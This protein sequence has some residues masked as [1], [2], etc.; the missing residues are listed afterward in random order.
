MK[1]TRRE[2]LKLTGLAASASLLL[3][4]DKAFA[5][6]V[7]RD[8]STQVGM[9]VDTTRCIGCQ[10]CEIAC[11]EANGLPPPTDKPN[12]GQRR[13]TGIDAYTVVNE[14]ESEKS[15]IFCKTQCM[16]CDQP[17]CVSACITNAMYKTPEGP[18]IWRENKCMGCRYCML[19]C[20]FD[21]P[22]FEYESINPRIRK[23][24]LCYDRLGD[25]KQPACVEACPQ[26][27]VQYG[28]RGDLLDIARKRIADHPAQYVHNIYGENEV[29]GTNVLYLSSVPFEQLGF[30]TDLG[31][32][33]YPE[34]TKTFLYSVPLVL[35]LGPAFMAGLRHATRPGDDKSH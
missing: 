14:I 32:V 7:Q 15:N 34:F 17:A 35:L 28:R 4:P 30:K 22:K 26:E 18:V 3:G 23:C 16:H 9:L 1:T 33:A 24:I 20:P 21:V 11:S 8:T 25:G 13:T 19:A 12:A 5:R 31:T 10:S 6:T 2:L 27:A 29:G